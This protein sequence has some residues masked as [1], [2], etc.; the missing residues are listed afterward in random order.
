MYYG[1]GTVL[2]GP[3][4]GNVWEESRSIL[5]CFIKKYNIE[6]ILM[7]CFKHSQITNNFYK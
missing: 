1:S 6:I 7:K 3:F 4:A 5:S 2:V